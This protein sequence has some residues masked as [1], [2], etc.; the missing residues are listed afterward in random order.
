MIE[1]L[2]KNG[3]EIRLLTYD[4]PWIKNGAHYHYGVKTETIVIAILSKVLFNLPTFDLACATLSPIR[5]FEKK[6]SKILEDEKIDIIQVENLWPLPPVLDSMESSLPV[7][8]TL[9]DVYSDRYSELI[10]Y[11][12][13]CPKILS[14]RLVNAVKRI[15]LEYLNRV[16]IAVCLTEEDKARYT[17]MGVKESKLK[18]IPGAIDITRIKPQNPDPSLRRKYML[19]KEDLVLFFAGSMMYQNKKAIDDIV[20]YILPRLLAKNSDFK[21]LI[22]GSIS[23]YVKK[24]GYSKN[25]P[26]IPLGYVEDLNKY[27]ALADIVVIPTR[28]GT[29]FKTKT[30]EAMAAGKPVVCTRKATRGIEVL[31]WKNIVIC[32][33]LEEIVNAILSLRENGELAEMIGKNARTTAEKYD[34]CRVF[35]GYLTLYEKLKS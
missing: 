30:L 21:I 35:K 23:K 32:E 5:F 31:N 24:R 28:L 2:K 7:I 15:E 9:H 14:E 19:G 22:A 1:V 3:V 11:T 27:Y 29:G 16:D 25:L 13:R 6:L 8:V 26:I 4:L 18:V 10:K 20:Q 34:L 33:N 17:S 12:S